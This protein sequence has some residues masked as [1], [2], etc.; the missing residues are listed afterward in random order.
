M[1][2]LSGMKCREKVLKISY[3]FFD[4]NEV[5]IQVKKFSRG[6]W[7]LLQPVY[8]VQLALVKWSDTSFV[9]LNRQKFVSYMKNVLREIIL[10]RG[11]PYA[12]A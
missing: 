11:P 12:V 7:N 6:T 8:Y 5:S 3:P 1:P 9:S 4:I 10:L 2:L